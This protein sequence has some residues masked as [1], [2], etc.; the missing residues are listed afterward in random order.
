MIATGRSAIGVRVKSSFAWW[1]FVDPFP[2]AAKLTRR[3]ESRLFGDTFHVEP[4]LAKQFL[5]IGDA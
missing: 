1:R 4:R 5:G 2:G 3:A